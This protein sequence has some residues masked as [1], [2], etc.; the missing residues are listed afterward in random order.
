[1][2]EKRP[3]LIFFFVAI[4][5]LAGFGFPKEVS[6]TYYATGTLI[7]TNLLNGVPVVTS[8]DS[9]F[10][11]TTLPS[12]STTLWVQ[13]A[14]SSTAGPWYD[15]Q[16]NLN[17]TTSI[18]NGTSSTD[19]SG[20]GWSGANFYYKMYFYTSDTSN[21]PVLEEIRVDYTS[22]TAPTTSTISELS[23]AVSPT[24][25]GSAV[26][27]SG[28]ISDP[29]TDDQVR[30]TICKTDAI[31]AS[32][33]CT[34]GAWCYDP[35][36]TT[37]QA[38]GAASCDYTALAGDTSS[39]SWYAY[40]CDDSNACTNMAEDDGTFYVNHEPVTGAIFSDADAVP[41]KNVGQD[42]T[43]TMP[44]VDSDTDNAKIHVCKTNAITLEACD[45][46]FWC[47]GAA[48]GTSSQTCAYT[49]AVGDGTANL[50]YVFG[51]DEHGLC[52]SS[53]AS[54]T[55]YVV[56]TVPPAPPVLP[57][58]GGMP[59]ALFNPPQPPS[60]GFRILIN[61]DA[62]YTNSLIVNLTIFGGSDATR[63]AIS[64]FSDFR[65]AIQETYK[66]AKSWNLCQDR[67]S[68][69]EGE[70]T[71]YVKFYASW[72]TA[73]EVVFDKIIYKKE[74]ALP[75]EII[76]K[77]SE[78]AQKIS[79]K[80]GEIAKKIAE[81]MKPPEVKPPEVPVEELVSKETPLAMKNQWNLLTYTLKNLPF[82]EFTL[83]PLPKEI[84]NLAESF[85][86]LKE[87]FSNVGIGKLIDVEK[88]RTTKMTLPGLTETIGLPT[89]K[90]EPGKFALPQ[91]V[92]VAEL[93]PEVKKQIPTE[94]V[95][96][97]T[98][99][100]LVDFNI[101]LSVTEKGDPQQKITTISGKPLN[102]V[103]KPDQPV[104][105]IKG[106]VIF[107]SK[108]K[109][110]TE[111]EILLDSLL[112]SVFFSNP[113]FAQDH[114]PEEIEEVLVLMEFEYTDPD[115]DG[116]YTADITAPLVEGEY[117]IITVMDYEDPDLGQKEIRLIT[118]VD[119]EGYIY[120]KAGEKEIRIPGAI[121]S[122]YWLNSET[123]QY[124]LWPAKGYQ[125][126]NP[127]V[128]DVTGKYSFLVPQGSYY[129]KVEAPG[130]LLDEGKPFQ[131]QEGSGIHFN[132]ELKTKLWYLKI[133]DWKTIL[134][135]LVIILLLYNFYRDRVREKTQ[136]V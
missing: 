21:T 129:L 120:E 33:Q 62:K 44:F 51:C 26:T 114:N 136:K 1:M 102:L 30:L 74:V 23:T 101:A 68:C 97:K 41:G 104:K 38:E 90:I 9:F 45:G 111:L 31:D 42:I 55:F 70:Y 94:I 63:M 89:I 56:A 109:K 69:P 76:E 77:I 60:G 107:K 34:G 61:N 122:L 86:Q 4:I 133:L 98:G 7:S 22:N 65:N 71:V 17:G 106:Y 100:E 82:F 6:A 50:Y 27:F 105:S 73:S 29:D 18:A 48:Y 91:G 15:D 12:A 28:N 131:I 53:S 10:A 54:S 20:L 115:G 75:I 110:T 124:E 132:I 72:E 126:E 118:V 49:T 5:I 39:S 128:T 84:R 52:D 88:L 47:N 3:I 116:I 92:P 81:L 25:V 113:I 16:G 11:S 112:A 35:S 119:P 43:F 19:L 85:P 36:S 125:Q 93:S 80:A 83:A 67:E 57:G 96:A 40:A 13:F 79:E 134:L 66:T 32:S 14:T 123:K 103:V 99:G 117:E 95:F 58:G 24:N 59:A 37:W 108:P 135:S 127:Q 130:Y 64:N 2:S 46:G 87:T 121:V 8:I 78:E